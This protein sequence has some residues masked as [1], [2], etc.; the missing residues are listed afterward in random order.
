MILPCIHEKRLTDQVQPTIELL[1]N[2]DVLHPDVL[3]QHN[4]VP[5][6]YKHG[7]VFRSAVESIRGSFAASTISGRHGLVGDVLENLVNRKYIATYKGTGTKARYD[8]SIQVSRDPD[9]FAAL[10]V[11][12]GEGNSINISERPIWAKEFG[13]WCH[14]DGAIVNQPSDGVHSIINRLTNEMVRREKQVDALL[15]KDMLCGTP[16]RPC[17]K[18]GDRGTCTGLLTA[19]DIFL[20]PQRIPSLRE[21]EPP[22]HSL[23]T[24]KLPRVVLDLFQVGSKDRKRHIWEVHVKVIK[25]SKNSLQRL[26]EVWHEGQKV[27]ESRS[28]TWRP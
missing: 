14:L 28:R 7:L 9:Y 16:T 22:V 23:D 5:N 11:K 18:Y 10:E 13:V 2:M 26:T 4:I 12:G 25:L 15:V 3:S 6:D 8:F 21:P 24:L 27:S 1:S 20:L 19:P 17:P